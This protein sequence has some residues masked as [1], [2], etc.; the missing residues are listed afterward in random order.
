M[1]MELKI[2]RAQLENSNESFINRIN[3][4]KDRILN[5]GEKREVLN[6][7]SKNNNKN[8]AQERNTQETWYHVFLQKKIPLN[9]RRRWGESQVNGIDK[10]FNKIIQENFLKPKK[11]MKHPYDKKHANPHNISYNRKTAYHS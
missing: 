2:P 7:I 3:Q 6:Q 8:K 11:D 4:A 5:L 10:I 9:Y 1:R